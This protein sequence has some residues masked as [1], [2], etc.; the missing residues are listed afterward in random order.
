[1]NLLHANFRKIINRCSQTNGFPNR[2]CSSFKSE[3]R[4]PLNLSYFDLER[5][6]W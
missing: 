6:S 3:T 4:E 2:R 1:M 5:Q